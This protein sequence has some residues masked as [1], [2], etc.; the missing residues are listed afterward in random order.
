[1]ARRA[2]RTE[3][4]AVVDEGHPHETQDLVD[5]LAPALPPARPEPAFLRAT[6]RL[7]VGVALAHV[8]GDLVPAQNVE[9][10]GW[11]DG[12]EPIDS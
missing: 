7:Y 9:P 1:M 4:P 11:A 8:P 12:V 10:N 2:D 3:P 6:K 5:E